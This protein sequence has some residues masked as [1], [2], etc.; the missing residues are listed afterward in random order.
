MSPRTRA[1]RRACP[2]FGKRSRRCVLTLEALENR[3]LLSFAAPVAFDLPTAPKAVAT[4]HFEGTHAPLDVVTANANGTVSVLLGKGDGTLQSPI[5]ISVGGS[6]TA[7]AVG[8]FL[9]NGLDDI[10]T[11][12]SN[13]TVD[14]LL[15][16]GN[17]TFQ[18]ARIVNVGEAGSALAAGDFRGDGKLDLALASASGANNV[19]L[20]LGNGNGTF[21]ATPSVSA[22][23]VL[24]SALATGVFTSSGKPDLVTTGIGGN[25]V[26]L[27]NNGDG[28]FRTGPTLSVTGSPMRWSSAISPATAA[29]TSPW[30]PR[31]G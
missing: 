19:T 28:T 25:A 30:A 1:S 6:L 3:R 29:R 11:A 16:N 18:A 4:G 15:S 27:L 9:H 10:V 14:L 24:P 23:S 8:D 26:V 12:N 5:T 7:V 31:R 2:T 21:A 22:G 20:F 13:G 17:G